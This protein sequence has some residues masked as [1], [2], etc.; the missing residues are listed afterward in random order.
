MHCKEIMRHNVRWILPRE[1]VAA[2]AK[3]MAFH[4]LGVLP[5]CSADGKPVGVVTD[6]DLALRVLGMDRLAPQTV[7]ED[8]MSSVVHAVAE[9]CPVDR[10]G[11]IM[12]AASVSRLLVLDEEGHLTGLVS[13]ADMLVHAPGK[14]AVA[15]ARGIYAREMSDRSAGHPHR[16]SRPTPKYFQ[17]ARD[18]RP[19]NDTAADNAA[20]IEANSVSHGGTNDL[21][22][23]PG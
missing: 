9:S 3:L 20:R 12:T 10:A 17:G 14:N 1:T 19:D 2:A 11:E 13:V 23:F 18:P 5:V 7:V 8:V 6:R 21:K 4:N 22:E 15:T 16:A